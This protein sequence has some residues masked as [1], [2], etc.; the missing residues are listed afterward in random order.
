MAL[1]ICDVEIPALSHY[2]PLEPSAIITIGSKRVMDDHT[3]DADVEKRQKAENREDDIVPP[4]DPSD[5]AQGVP[6]REPL[7]EKGAAKPK[8]AQQDKDKDESNLDGE[9]MDSK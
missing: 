9:P 1:A 8:A 3:P 4:F 6:M 5:E 7:S 2:V